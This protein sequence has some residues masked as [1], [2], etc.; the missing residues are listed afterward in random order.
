MIFC[1]FF[2]I[3]QN[4]LQR[5]KK[6]CTYASV[7]AIFL[8]QSD[9]AGLGEGLGEGRAV[10]GGVDEIDTQGTGAGEAGEE[11]VVGEVPAERSDGEM[12]ATA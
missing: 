3:K 9:F 10:V 7:R 6:K 4:P 11:K 1:Y 8:R 12:A 2:V 5:Y